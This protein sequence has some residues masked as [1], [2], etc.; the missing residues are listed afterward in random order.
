S[1]THITIFMGDVFSTG[2]PE[3]QIGLISCAICF[4]PFQN[5]EGRASASEC[6]RDVSP[7]YGQWCAKSSTTA[8]SQ[9]GIDNS[10]KIPLCHRFRAR[11]RMSAPQTTFT[12]KKIAKIG[13]T[14]RAQ[15]NG[16]PVSECNPLSCG[17][18]QLREARHT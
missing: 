15:T 11:A 4:Q 1:L 8:A 6:N 18:A 10:Q 12:T 17:I 2:G 16:S 14:D 5:R 9:I 3:V 13:I 7:I